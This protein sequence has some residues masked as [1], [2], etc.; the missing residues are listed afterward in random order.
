[1]T[2]TTKDVN[3]E[4]VAQLAAKI[5]E[6]AKY[7]ERQSIIK[8]AM[9]DWRSEDGLSLKEMSAEVAKVKEKF[10]K[11]AG[12]LID[13]LRDFGK[14]IGDKPGSWKLV[15]LVFDTAH[16]AIDAYGYDSY[17]NGNW[18]SSGY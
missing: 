5:P 4:F 12:E 1:M 9:A 10:D 2:F 17:E 8:A 13:A 16:A 7:F 18:I 3:A 14:E 15:D 6:G 11:Q